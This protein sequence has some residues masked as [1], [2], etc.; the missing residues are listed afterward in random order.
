M[1]ARA[2]LPDLLTFVTAET[3]R[4]ADALSI[5]RAWDFDMHAQSVAAAIFAA[6]WLRLPHALV[7]QEI[8]SRLYRAFE[9]W[10]SCVDRFVR[11]TLREAQASGDA[12][13]RAQCAQIVQESF[14][15]ALTDLERRLGPD[16]RAWQWGRVHR[17]VFPHTPFHQVPWLRRWFSRSVATGGDWSTI[18]VGGTWTI[19]R[20][21]EQRYVAGYRQVIDLSARDGG[22]FIHP[23]GQIGARALTSLRRLSRGLGGLPD[24]A[25]A[26]C[27]LDRGTRA[28][29]R[30]VAAAAGRDGPTPTTRKGFMTMSHAIPDAAV[31][32]EFVTACHGKL[33]LAKSLLDAYPSLLD[34]RSKVDESG[35][36]AAAHMGQRAIAELL[37]ERGAPLD[38]CT[39][40]MLG[41]QADVRKM[42]AS[43]PDASAAAGAHGIPVMAYAAISGD[44]AIAELLFAKG[45]PVNGGAGPITPL[46]AAI[47]FDRPEMVAWLV[48]RGASLD[49]TDFTG[50]TPQQMAEKLKRERILDLLRQHTR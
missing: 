21:F 42:L 17:A 48:E 2:L 10:V 24:A 29:Q 3:P 25:D 27:A 34:A 36:E 23:M 50:H 18:S 6:W 5:L 7:E 28:T 1:H 47:G 12:G 37:L 11:N 8:G 39:A 44:L 19:A 43:M 35:L 4:E 32:E 22:E 13:A 41:R 40:A 49:A 26:P 30:V 9:G 45:A 46:H 20:P 16:L 14:R 33:E 15:R 38:L 31:I